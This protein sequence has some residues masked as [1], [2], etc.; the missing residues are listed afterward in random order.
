MQ[1]NEK[2]GV[3][4]SGGRAA[5]F[6]AVLFGTC[7]ATVSWVGQSNRRR[8]YKEGNITIGQLIR[9]KRTHSKKYFQIL[10]SITALKIMLLFSKCSLG[11]MSNKYRYLCVCNF[12]I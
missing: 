10:M 6:S 5:D 8:G 7:H 11:F 2:V 12:A 1:C 9:T 4:F 3:I